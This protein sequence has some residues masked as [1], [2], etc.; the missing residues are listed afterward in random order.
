MKIKCKKLRKL[1]D[2]QI[3]IMWQAAVNQNQLLQ[4]YLQ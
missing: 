4:I 3:K 2:F 1:C